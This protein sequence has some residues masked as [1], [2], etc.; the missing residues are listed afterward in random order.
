[1][2]DKTDT[3][4]ISDAEAEWLRKRVT[5]LPLDLSDKGR[6][7]DLLATRAALLDAIEDGPI[8]GTGETYHDQMM[9][10]R[11]LAARIRKEE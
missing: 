5:D 9:R 8:D 1:M 4:Y 7:T 2:A 11:G 6:L 3:R 10:L